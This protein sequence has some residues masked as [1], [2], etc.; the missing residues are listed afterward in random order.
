MVRIRAIFRIITT[1]GTIC[2]TL[3]TGLDFSWYAWG[4]RSAIFERDWFFARVLRDYVT[5]EWRLIGKPFFFKSVDILLLNCILWL[6]SHQHGRMSLVMQRN[7]GLLL[8]DQR[9]LLKLGC[10]GSFFFAF[11]S[12][13]C[14]ILLFE[15]ITWHNHALLVCTK[16]Q[17]IW[18]CAQVLLVLLTVVW[19]STGLLLGCWLEN[20]ATILMISRK[21]LLNT[22]VAL[23]KA[24]CTASHRHIHHNLI[25][26]HVST[27]I[28]LI[29]LRTPNICLR[30]TG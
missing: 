13:D 20:C 18:E 21:H 19:E 28:N 9:W 26:C 8:I 10:K 23:W 29:S 24:A 11:Y 22:Q 6:I 30:L 14:F 27:A 25:I 5:I 4:N 3:F 7:H 1:F 15:N 2:K 16:V 12:K 17:S